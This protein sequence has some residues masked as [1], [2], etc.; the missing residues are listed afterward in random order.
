MN[1]VYLPYEHE[2]PI[3]WLDTNIINEIVDALK[4]KTKDG[5]R[6][7]NILLLYGLLRKLVREKKI[8]CPFSGQRT[9][10]GDTNDSGLADDVLLELSGGFQVSTWKVD[11]VQQQRMV[12]LFLNGTHEFELFDND[13][14]YREEKE[15][16]NEY[17]LKVV[18]LLERNESNNRK[19]LHEHLVRRQGEIKELGLSRQE[20]YASEASARQ[21]NLNMRIKQL[22]DDETIMRAVESLYEQDAMFSPLWPLYCFKEKTGRHMNSDEQRLYVSGKYMESTPWD[23]ISAVLFSWLLCEIKK[24]TPQHIGDVSHLSQIFPYASIIVTEKQM[25]HALEVS[26]LQQEFNT[27]IYT[28]KPSSLSALISKLQQM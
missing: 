12:E 13:L 25:A 5:E 23:R 24:L 7:K 28:L 22:G 19:R 1:F 21:L 6:T 9:E 4:G 20:V 16:N 15:P 3:V 26:G 2:P 8:V 18:I 14:R 27:E 11:V 17:G 10:Y